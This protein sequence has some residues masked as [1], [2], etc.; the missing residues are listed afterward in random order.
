M[1]N[2]KEK[3]FCAKIGEFMSTLFVTCIAVCLGACMIALTLRFITWL[4]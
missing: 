2:E 1:D 3:N 4:F